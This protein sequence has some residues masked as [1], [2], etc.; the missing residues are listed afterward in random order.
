MRH[1]KSSILLLMVTD[2]L[3]IH[4]ILENAG[5]CCYRLE[6]VI[7]IVSDPEVLFVVFE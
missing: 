4:K 1:K 2:N 3:K 6:S 5:S 7:A